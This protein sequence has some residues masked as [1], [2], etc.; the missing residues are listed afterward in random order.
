MTFVLLVFALGVTLIFGL[1]PLKDT[2]WS[3]FRQEFGKV[4]S[5]AREERY[6]RSVWEDN[7][8][9]IEDHNT[10]ARNGAHPF[11]LASN[12]FADMSHIEFVSMTTGLRM[13][14]GSSAR[15]ERFTFPHEKMRDLPESV[16]WR[17]E[18]YVTPV[19][20]QGQCGAC[21][22][23]ST[24][25]SL[26]GQWFKKTGKLVSLSEQNL[27][28]CSKTGNIGCEGGLMEYAFNYIKTNDGIN[29]EDDYPYEARDGECRYDGEREVAKVTGFQEI[30]PFSEEDQKAAV[31]EV[32]PVSI[33]IDAS[34]RS[35]QF[36]SE[37]V[38]EEAACS[39]VL[40]N[41]AVLAVGY[42]SQN[43]QDFWIMKNSWGTQWGDAG[44]FKIARNQ[45]NMCGIATDS[46][47]PTV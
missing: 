12:R 2:E 30:E 38:Y 27:V 6:R 20:D 15:H 14:N 41:H 3:N 4:Y 29:T 17:S 11:V 7:L 5:G 32:G 34:H 28:D 46:S 47:F 18:G 39:P 25:G 22:A 23:F 9:Y 26:E 40:L 1:D 8:R 36:Y 33:A 31:A 43:G 13:R 35:F 16:D 42:G 19:K 21:W 24:T 10:R 44:Y 37:G 45:D